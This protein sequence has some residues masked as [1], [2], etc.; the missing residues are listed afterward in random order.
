MSPTL[1]GAELGVNVHLM[2]GSVT[3][4]VLLHK[5]SLLP[6]YLYST[7]PT[8][9][10]DEVTPSML[11]V[12]VAIMYVPDIPYVLQ[13]APTQGTSAP[14][15]FLHV[16]KNWLAYPEGM[17]TGDGTIWQLFATNVD[18]PPNLTVIGAVASAPVIPGYLANICASPLRF[19]LVG[20]AGA[21]YFTPPTVS[22]LVVPASP[23]VLL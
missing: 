5:T 12:G 20:T 8:D 6:S 3:L 10:E 15:A 4:T 21:L 1:I 2:S 16:T 17:S 14:A 11:I 13:S 19:P 9:P 18:P 22:S 7:D 23:S